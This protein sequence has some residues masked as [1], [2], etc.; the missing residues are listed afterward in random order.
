MRATMRS[1]CLWNARVSVSFTP[2]TTIS[3]TRSIPLVVGGLM[4]DIEI[5]VIIM[6]YLFRLVT[7]R[8]V[9]ADRHARCAAL[10]IVCIG[11]RNAPLLLPTAKARI[12]CVYFKPHKR[13]SCFSAR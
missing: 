3:R 2:S 9:N 10:R 6:N 5:I 4:E 8:P 13:S 7:R 12:L 11:Y 1:T